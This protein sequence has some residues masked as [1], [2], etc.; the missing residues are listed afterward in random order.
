MRIMSASFLLAGS[1]LTGCRRPVETI[2]PFA[3]AP[4][5]LV[6]G[7]PLTYATAMPVRASAIPL[8]VKTCEGRPIKIEGNPG[9]PWP[10]NAVSG[11]PPPPPQGPTDAAAQASILSLYDPDRARRFTRDG[12]TIPR[13]LALDALDALA[14]QAADSRGRG[15]C[16]L[17]DASSSPS[18][19]RLQRALAD[20]L[21][22]SRWFEYEP[23]DLAAYRRTTRA[24]FGRLL[25]PL[26]RLDVARRI[27]SWDCDFLG[28]EEE[29]CRWTRAF[30]AGRRL[31][32][33][34]NEP[35]RLY[36]IESL[37][38]LTGMN[39]DHRLRLAPSQ[40]ALVAARLLSECISA[41]EPHQRPAGALAFKSRLQALA[42][43]TTP[44][45][46]AW[47]RACAGDLTAQ[48]DRSA[49]LA[50]HRQPAEVHLWAH[51]L[52]HLLRGR[53][54]AVVYLDRP[55]E[56]P[57]GTLAELAAALAADEVRILVILAG[58]PA[59]NAPADL[60]WARVQSRADTVVR[61]GSCEDETFPACHWHLPMAHYLESWGDARTADGTWLSIQPLIAPLFGGL[62]DLEVLARL[63]GMPVTEPHEIVRETFRGLAP[64]G[65][66]EANWRR[67]LHDGTW[68]GTAYPEATVESFDWNAATAALDSI[69]EV[70]APAP[71]ALEVV[72]ARDSRV[73]DGRY[74]NNGWL[75]EL[76]D[77]VTKITWDNVIALSPA[78]ARLLGL[79][80][81]EPR[82]HLEVP[83]VRVSAGGRAIEGPL[84]IQPGLADDVVGLTLGHGRTRA[85]RV[86]TG[87]GYD[88][89][90]LR[91]SRAMHSLAGAQLAATGRVHPLAC[92]QNHGRLEGRPIVRET[93]LAEFRNHPGFASAMDRDAPD[94]S[95]L[96]ANPLDA[97]AAGVLHQWGMT[98]DLGLCVGCAACVVACQSENNIPIVGKNEVA[99]QREMH[100]LRIDRYYAGPADDPQGVNQPML[101]Q[102]C[103]SAPCES[104]CPVN[105]TVHDREG[106]NVMVYNRCIGTR[107]CSNN[108]PYKVRRFNFFDY[109][110]RPDR[111]SRPREEWDL[112]SLVRNPDVT[113]RMRGVIEKCTF[114]V[115]RLEQ[116]K[117]ARAVSA[118]ASPPKA[119][120]DGEV[121]TACQQACPAGAIEF[122][123]LRDPASRVSRA[124][125]NPRAYAVLQSLNTR[126]RVLYLARVR[127]PNP[128]MPGAPPRP[129]GMSVEVRDP[130]MP[131]QGPGT[132][133]GGNGK[134]GA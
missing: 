14:H 127:N 1:G 70:R 28:N 69:R 94:S 86:G 120:A 131:E 115:Q 44:E 72:F 30:A 114:C 119:V 99:R 90:P 32:N 27:V 6:H 50:G 81:P 25:Q 80:V 110:R 58:N 91:T 23:V 85:G 92:T 128:A 20:R 35:S 33:P 11:A 56:P 66:F 64:D 7:L 87:T 36:A 134:E 98:I 116:A 123:N 104:V 88:A 3:Q 95:P 40:M 103:E 112:L 42:R 45:W 57:A 48:P 60:E 74:A 22:E 5:G 24:A 52:N 117:I 129:H 39:A 82:E 68:A 41:L 124:R 96:Y 130:E 133:E 113:V 132:V 83:V 78:T 46:A 101:C 71:D 63:A 26:Y 65:A 38:T 18:R 106:L 122:G 37:L 126:P 59:Y 12:Q 121:Q 125:A 10:L 34:G 29:T 47:T 51:G 8:R 43:T 67:L 118:G 111:G 21:P 53:G 76:P 55:P 9:I 54:A 97:A 49:V 62:T 84:W 31:D 109:H 2:H 15:L 75:E 61:L 19:A 13:K 73:D 79:A 93:N 107:H 100:W 77:P 105:A 17:A 89:Y 4:E 102:H 16:I 108:C